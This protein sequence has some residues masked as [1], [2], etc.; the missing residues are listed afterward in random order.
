[1]KNIKT[2]L[3]LSVIGVSLALAGF[4]ISEAGVN[5]ESSSNQDKYYNIDMS[6]LEKDIKAIEDGKY[7]YNWDDELDIKYGDNWD[8]AMESKYGEQWDDEFEIKIEGKKVNENNLF[9][10]KLIE[11]IE[12]DLEDIKNGNIAGDWEDKIDAKYGDDWEDL[13]EAKYGD[14]WEDQFERELS[15][16]YPNIKFDD[17]HDNDDCDDI[18]ND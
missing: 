11:K 1:M 8:D 13:I 18:D 17:I 15:E 7:R 2:L 6:A 14:D 4:K 10:E 9:N 16:K 12:S 3:T 5:T